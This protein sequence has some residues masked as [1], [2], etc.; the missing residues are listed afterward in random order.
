VA[1]RGLFADAGHAGW[2]HSRASRAGPC[3]NAA[4][5]LLRC[6]SICS[7]LRM[8]AANSALTAGGTF[9]ARVAL[10]FFQRSCVIFSAPVTFLHI[11]ITMPGWLYLA[12]PPS[13][14]RGDTA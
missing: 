7:L 10:S 3:T 5:A 1:P 11:R 6:C 13:N 9:S 14:S 8:A 12:C 2:Q 4:R